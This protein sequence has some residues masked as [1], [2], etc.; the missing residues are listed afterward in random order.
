MSEKQ[1]R[2]IELFDAGFNC[3][4]AVIGVFSDELNIDIS[5]ALRM[6]GG[7][8]HGLRSGEICGAFSGAAMLVGLRDGADDPGDQTAK[9]SC[10]AQTLELMRTLKARLG[11]CQCRDILVN[12]ALKARGSVTCPDC[13]R[14]PCAAAIEAAVQ[15]LEE[16]GF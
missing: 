1:K 3:A 16:R 2:A 12:E 14:R 10:N 4:Q 13:T 15:A 6:A 7:F 5:T 8:G 11:V 9:N